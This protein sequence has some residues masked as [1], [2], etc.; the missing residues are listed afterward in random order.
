MIECS[1]SPPA[2]PAIVL[3]LGR[4]VECVGDKKA[5]SEGNGPVENGCYLMRGMWIKGL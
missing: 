5:I 3:N 2:C 4:K 1:D